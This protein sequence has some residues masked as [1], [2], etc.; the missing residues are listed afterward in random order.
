MT[1]F[2]ATGTMPGAGTGYLLRP[3]SG[4]K[5]AGICAAFARAYGWDVTTVR[6]IAI[7]LA[8]VTAPL[9]EFAYIAAWVLIPEEAFMPYAQAYPPNTQTASSQPATINGNDTN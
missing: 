5:I 6:I 7:I 3:R 1:V 9:S 2:S 8:V 4:R